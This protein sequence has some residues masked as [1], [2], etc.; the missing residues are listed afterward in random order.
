MTFL[1]LEWAYNFLSFNQV[2][3]KQIISFSCIHS[4]KDSLFNYFFQGHTPNF[5]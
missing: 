1:R 2:D 4:Y 5:N 3:I